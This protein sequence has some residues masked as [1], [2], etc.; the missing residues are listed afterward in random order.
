MKNEKEPLRCDEC[1]GKMIKDFIRDETYC[2]KCGL[3]RN[4][5]HPMGKG[6]SGLISYANYR[7]LNDHIDDVRLIYQMEGL[8]KARLMVMKL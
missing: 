1:N 2:E 7:G 3:V 8:A 6:L 5:G 4:P